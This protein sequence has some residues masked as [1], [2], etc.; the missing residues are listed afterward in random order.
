MTR[1]AA[2]ELFG[3]RFGGVPEYVVRSPGRVNLIGEHTDYNDGFVFPMAIEQSTWLALRGRDD[4]QVHVA[5]IGHRDAQFDI[6]KV[7]KG[8]SGWAEYLKGLA[9][10]IGPDALRGWEG[11]FA[12]DIPTGAGLS[13]SAALGIAGARA[14][15]AVS[16]WV[17]DAKTAARAARRSENEWI[18]VN[19]GIMDQLVI[20]TGEAGHAVLIDCRSLELHTFLLPADVTVVILDTGTRRQSV[21]SEYDDRRAS[22]ARAAE[23]ANVSALRDLS[24]ESLPMLAS[25]V[26][27]V[28]LRR[29]RHVISENTRTVEAAAALGIGDIDRF[30]E[31]M[32]GSHRSLRDDYEVSSTELDAMVE[33]AS[34]VEG[35]HGARMTGAGFGGCAV[36]LVDK[37]A[38]CGFVEEVG[39][40]YAKATSHNPR[41]YATTPT[42][43]AC[44]DRFVTDAS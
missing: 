34:N 31:Y 15:A 32:G 12:T 37:T 17:W 2:I 7:V 28:T 26:D 41:I 27:S 25:A 40:R 29:A 6:A 30:G 14:F 4:N 38:V 13:S 43:G 42:A 3:I 5:S 23:A 18:G 24:L 21:S 44:V 16:D 36:A 1:E 10:A 9:W 20:A 8:T 19:T 22:C 11:A 33:I 39:Q 35:C